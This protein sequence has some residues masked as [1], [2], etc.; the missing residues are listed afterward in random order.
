MYRSKTANDVLQR[1]DFAER[2]YAGVLIWRAKHLQKRVCRFGLAMVG[3]DDL[4]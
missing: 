3:Y 2:P 1:A 4:P